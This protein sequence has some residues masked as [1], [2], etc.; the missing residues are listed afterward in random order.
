MRSRVLW[1]EEKLGYLFVNIFMHRCSVTFNILIM[2]KMGLL[3]C[4][5]LQLLIS[6]LII[7]YNNKFGIILY[8]LCISKVQNYL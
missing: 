6:F 3:I 4:R 8:Y 7:I 5:E 2:S 1:S